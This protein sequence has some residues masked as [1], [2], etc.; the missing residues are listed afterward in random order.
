MAT[1]Q[2]DDIA[3]LITITQKDLGRLRWTDLSYDLQEYIAL[4]SLL[5]KECSG[6]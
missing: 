2:A 3:D 4:P 6:T 5:Q 1:L